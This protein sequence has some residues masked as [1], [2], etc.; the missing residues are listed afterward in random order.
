MGLVPAFAATEPG[1]ENATVA[2]IPGDLCYFH[3]GD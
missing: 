2:P 3:M 1:K